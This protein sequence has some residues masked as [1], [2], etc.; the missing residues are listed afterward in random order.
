MKQEIIVH[1]GPKA[2]L[3][4]VAFGGV[5]LEQIEGNR[6]QHFHVLSTLLVADTGTVFTKGDIHHAMKAVLK[7][8]V[9]LGG[10]QQPG[11]I[12]GKTAD[13]VLI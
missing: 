5:T 12:G 2:F 10:L 6:A 3:A 1:G 13:L 4:Q 11:C 7:R 9:M 8:P